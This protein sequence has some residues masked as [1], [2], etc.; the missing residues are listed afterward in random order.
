M[1]FLAIID[2]K[3]N[4]HLWSKAIVSLSS[5]ADQIKFSISPENLSISAVNGAKTSH[6]DVE[7]H[8][9]FFRDYSVS[10]DDVV[11]DI[12]DL[13]LYSFI[14][15]AKHIATIFKNVDS[16]DS[17][18]ICMKIQGSKSAPSITQYKLLIEIETKNLLVKKHHVSYQP[19]LQSQND[20]PKFYREKWTQQSADRIDNRD[21]NK[22]NYMMIEQLVL[23]QFVDTVPLSTEDFKIDLKND[24]ILFSGY[25]KLILKEIDYLK[26]PMS[27]TI[28]LDLEELISSNFVA[29]QND[30]LQRRT[31]DFRLRDFK[32]FMNLIAT[33]RVEIGDDEMASFKDNSDCFEIL[34]RQPGDPVLFELINEKYVTVR[35][36]QMTSLIIDNTE[37]N[38]PK[39][40]QLQLSSHQLAHISESRQITPV[41]IAIN[42][43]RSHHD[44]PFELPPTG[45]LGRPLNQGAKLVRK[46]G[47]VSP[48]R[49]SHG[50]SEQD[51]ITYGSTDMTGLGPEVEPA[52]KRRRASD[53]TDYSDSDN[54]AARS[55]SIPTVVPDSFGPTQLHERPKSIFE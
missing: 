18:Y 39:S 22:V 51:F 28:T 34:F 42:V 37:N 46:T 19:V 17:S 24:K 13:H 25:T 40:A 43:D 36:I 54:D 55:K 15:N 1:P 8:P 31:I 7:F 21:P 41:P 10:L 50:H 9:S 38:I 27:V 11:D 47:S 20:I 53:A 49:D 32:N 2:S 14:V 29:T 30:P 3:K 45:K 44:R 12:Q 6:A 16:T 35:F 33:V 48:A 52:T 26:Q 4:Q 23:R 5:I